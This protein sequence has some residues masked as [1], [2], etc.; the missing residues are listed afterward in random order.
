[1]LAQDMLVVLCWWE[2]SG[3]SEKGFFRA[4]DEDHT[5]LQI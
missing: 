3:V 4:R 5:L 1:M 2:A